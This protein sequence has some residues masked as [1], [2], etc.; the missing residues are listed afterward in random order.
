MGLQA[1]GAHIEE[2]NPGEYCLLRGI[3]V[4]S[5]QHQLVEVITRGDHR[6]AMSFSLLA[7]RGYRV[8]FDSPDVVVK[9]YPE[10]WNEL[11]RL[12]MRWQP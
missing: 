2:R 3:P 4:A 8:R 7:S 6:M 9:S 1:F 10:Y 5:D 12:G 11:E